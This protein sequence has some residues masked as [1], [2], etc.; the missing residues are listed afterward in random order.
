[1]QRDT[2][3]SAVTSPGGPP[4]VLLAAVCLA[5]AA[6]RSDPA[7]DPA[8]AAPTPANAQR[9]PADDLTDVRNQ[10]GAAMLR[11]ELSHLA[12]LAPTDTRGIEVGARQV[13]RT[14]GWLELRRAPVPPAVA[15]IRPVLDAA[16]A[17]SAGEPPTMPESPSLED[18]GAVMMTGAYMGIYRGREG[19]GSVISTARGP[20]VML[21][22]GWPSSVGYGDGV[23][24]CGFPVDI[25]EEVEVRGKVQPAR[26]YQLTEEEDCRR[27]ERER[28]ANAKALRAARE[29][30]MEEHRRAMAEYREQLAE[31]NRRVESFDRIKREAVAAVPAAAAAAVSRL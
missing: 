3:P 16:L 2:T 26:F 25:E 5:L 8:R 18:G 29:E 14:V 17:D 31:H 24:A 13:L 6:C 9:R 23:R 21:L 30:A 19:E 27:A 12:G 11:R 7:P 22:A 1:M 4:A 15:S 20:V 28:R 10:R